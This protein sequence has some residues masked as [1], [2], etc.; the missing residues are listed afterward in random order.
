MF[1]NF[2]IDEE[3]KITYTNT[4]NIFSPAFYQKVPDG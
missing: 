3:V 4:F 2:N 1:A